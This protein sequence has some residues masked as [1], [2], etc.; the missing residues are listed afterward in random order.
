MAFIKA[1]LRNKMNASNL[2]RINPDKAFIA[3]GVLLC[4]LAFLF[5]LT[6]A[7]LQNAILFFVLV[8][9]LI[10][11]ERG[12]LLS[13]YK[14]NITAKIGALLFSY[15]ALSILWNGISEDTFKFLLKY[16]EFILIGTLVA[17][18]TN[19]FIFK[20]T[21]RAF[22]LG[23][24]LTLVASYLI[25]FDLW[26]WR[27]G[28]WNSLHARIFH[29]LQ[30][31][32]L[33]LICLYQILI[34]KKY[35]A[36]SVTILVAIVIN[37]IF[38]EP[39]RNSQLTMLILLAFFGVIYLFQS[40]GRKAATIFGILIAFISLFMAF[41]EADVRLLA[42]QS[43]MQNAINTMNEREIRNLDVRAAFYINGFR[44]L[45]ERPLSG[46]GLGNTKQPYQQLKDSQ[47]RNNEQDVY[48]APNHV[49]NQ[50]LQI[51]L[52][53]GIMGGILFTIFLI[54]ILF[55]KHISPA[56]KIGIFIIT[57]LSNLFNSSFLDHGDGWILMLVISLL[58][59][60]SESRNSFLQL[61]KS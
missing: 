45:S 43:Q 25:Y 59:A 55:L 60:K 23:L 24:I 1:L 15:L 22:L 9:F 36:F 8:T 7:G 46:Y 39:G 6:R 51:S 16:R 17:L 37:L 40:G 54:S 42:N 53:A 27:N 48:S 47:K 52:E 34:K 35:S 28:G 11:K 38:I 31:N 61:K 26:F 49:H 14:T 4:A 3:S 57:A 44:L 10:S 20:L 30:M 12:S 50:F 33:L 29:G 32:I 58:I 41:K 2:T 56:L 21:Y 18:L 5:P 19:E 13:I